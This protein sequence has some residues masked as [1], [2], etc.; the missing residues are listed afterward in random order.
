MTDDQHKWRRASRGLAK[1][2]G[3][4]ESPAELIFV[5]SLFVAGFSD[6]A[7][8]IDAQVA[9]PEH[10]ARLDFEV[11]SG[12]VRVD[13]EIDGWGWHST[14]QQL[15]DDDARD[16]RLRA[17]G[18]RIMR[19]AAGQLWEDATQVGQEALHWLRRIVTEPPQPLRTR[20]PTEREKDKAETISA[21]KAAEESG[22]TELADRLLRA[23]CERARARRLVREASGEGRLP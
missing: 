4:C 8:S 1:V 12:D 5:A 7:M 18:W 11:R 20:E 14:P 9:V 19:I 10:G 21:L 23:V 6:S 16:E 2:I 17:A 15:A 3:R 22:D 13:I